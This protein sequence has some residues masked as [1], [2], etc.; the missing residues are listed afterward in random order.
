[1]N[2]VSYLFFGL[3]I[4]SLGHS[5]VTAETYRAKLETS[6]FAM[7]GEQ[8]GTSVL[9]NSI[10]FNLYSTGN[11]RPISNGYSGLLQL[12]SGASSFDFTIFPST[13]AN[14]IIT[15]GVTGF[16]LGSPTGTKILTTST[17]ANAVLD[18]GRGTSVNGTAVFY[19]SS[20][21]SHF[22]YGTNEDTY[23]RGGKPGSRVILNDVQGSFSFTK[24]GIESTLV[25]VNYNNPVYTFEVRQSGG[26]GLKFR[27]STTGEWEW[28][29]AGS[30][31]N[32]YVIYNGSSK[33]Y[34]E[35]ADGDYIQLS[36]QRLKTG[37]EDLPSVLEKILKLRPTDYVMKET[38]PQQ[39]RS[40][41]FIAQEVE[42]VF[43]QLVHKFSNSQLGLLYSCFAPIAVK[44]IQ[45][46]QELINAEFKF[47]EEARELLQKTEKKLNQKN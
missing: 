47:Q 1:M 14:T 3:L 44:A 20:F 41:G 11:L 30:P 32:F 34:F 2:R 36:D 23:I 40:I 12:N 8:H 33:G 6:G 25:G 5:Q 18:V 39:R 29:V 22:N 35:A 19:G 45:E 38:N 43:P 15:G 7:F 26:T 37:I 16:R 24:M 21:S 42:E 28:R 10:G 4:T 46:Q 27:P 9:A 17:L 13:T 31:A